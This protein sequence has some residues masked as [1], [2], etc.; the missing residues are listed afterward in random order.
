MV[1][2][3]IYQYWETSTNSSAYIGKAC[4]LWGID[5]TLEVAHRRHLSGHDPVP[6]DF[7]LRDD[8][9]G[10]SLSVLDELEASTSGDL[11]RILKPLEKQR[12]RTIKPRYNRVRFL[13][14]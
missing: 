1:Y 5:K 12:V 2:G 4:G 3:I 11:Q 7:L 13:R 6:F 8:I 9:A 14:H 10:F